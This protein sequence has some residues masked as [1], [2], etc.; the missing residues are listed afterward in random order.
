MHRP[1]VSNVSTSILNV[2]H[3]SF[4]KYVATSCQEYIAKVGTFIDHH[5]VEERK[6]EVREERRRRFL[7]AMDAPRFMQEFEQLLLS[8][9]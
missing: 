2:C 6:P 3:E 1:H 4:E 8:I 5:V 9:L 7:E